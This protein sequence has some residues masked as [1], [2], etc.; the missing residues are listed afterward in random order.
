L[1]QEGVEFRNPNKAV[2]GWLPLEAYDNKELDTRAPKDW[3]I[4]KRNRPS[5]ATNT[6]AQ[7]EGSQEGA[8]ETPKSEGKKSVTKLM[9]TEIPA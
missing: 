4:V 7:A 9:K 5:P 3:M 8:A 1:L 2:G 6:R